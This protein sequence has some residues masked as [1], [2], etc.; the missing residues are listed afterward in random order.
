MKII[1]ITQNQRLYKT[2]LFFNYLRILHN[3]DD[4]CT[5][6]FIQ[7]FLAWVD[8]TKVDNIERGKK[9]GVYEDPVHKN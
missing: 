1:S 8:T 5:Q 7:M 9:T 6:S 3:L 2:Y 4:I